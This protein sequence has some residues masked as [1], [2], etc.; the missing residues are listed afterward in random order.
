MLTLNGRTVEQVK[1]V[2]PGN[3]ILVPIGQRLA[4]SLRIDHPSPAQKSTFPAIVDLV[5]ERA[6]RKGRQPIVTDGL[7]NDFC[8]DLRTKAIV[9]WNSL[10]E[11]VHI[12]MCP[13]AGC[14]AVYGDKEPGKLAI[15]STY[16][17]DDRYHHWDLQSGQ[18]ATLPSSPT[19]VWFISAWEI[20]IATSDTSF[21]K[22]CTFPDDFDA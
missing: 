18:L 17:T 15:S 10:A 7:S 22:I 19:A 16:A 20:G 13:R 12:G 9:R 6:G 11:N 21:H 5:G 1:A 8:L 3:L 14:I 4:L 2:P